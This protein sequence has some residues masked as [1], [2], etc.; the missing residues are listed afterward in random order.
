[1]KVS[2]TEHQKGKSGL[3]VTYL[4]MR[5]LKCI[6]WMWQCSQVS[7][8]HP[9][10]LQISSTILWEAVWDEAEGRQTGMHMPVVVCK[11]PHVKHSCIFTNGSRC[12][13]KG[14]EA[15]WKVKAQELSFSPNR[16]KAPRLW[17]KCYLPQIFSVKHIN[18]ILP[19][20]RMAPQCMPQAK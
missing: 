10:Q 8:E 14:W 19:T 20:R 9:L 17:T 2:Y 11:S 3:G 4:C 18:A 13:L 15:I 6:P 1:M 12:N 16:R 5:P 7:L